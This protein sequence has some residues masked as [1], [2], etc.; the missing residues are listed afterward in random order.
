MSHSDEFF[1]SAY[2]NKA[3]IVQFFNKINSNIEKLFFKLV[4]KL[5]DKQGA[6]DI[7]KSSPTA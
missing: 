3:E 1:I 6:A 2:T 5:N 7:P 4:L